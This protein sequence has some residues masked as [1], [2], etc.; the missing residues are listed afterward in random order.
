MTE[1]LPA[2]ITP[3]TITPEASRTTRRA[4]LAAVLAA[5]D[6][7][8][9]CDPR[10]PDDALTSALRRAWD[11]AATGLDGT[12]G[13]AAAAIRT[14]AAHHAAGNVEDAFFALQCARDHL[15]I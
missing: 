3:T 1:L 7:L 11:A 4:V 10:R 2:T 14:A 15:E 9:E 12:A 13:R 8:Y 6:A 5:T